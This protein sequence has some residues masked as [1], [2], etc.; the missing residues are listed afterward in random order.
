MLLTR[1]ILSTLSTKLLNREALQV[2]DVSIVA[3]DVSIVATE[4]SIVAFDRS[5]TLSG[6]RRRKSCNHCPDFSILVGIMDAASRS[7]RKKKRASKTK[8]IE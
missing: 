4:M 2:E 1:N 7:I 6:V 8:M 5:Q 3:T